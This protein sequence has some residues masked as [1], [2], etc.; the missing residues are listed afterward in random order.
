MI[1]QMMLTRL[2]R[3]ALMAEFGKAFVCVTEKAIQAG[4]VLYL[5]S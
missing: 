1:K 5:I 3:E 2:E 4:T